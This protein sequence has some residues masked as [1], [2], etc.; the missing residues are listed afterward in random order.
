[1][2]KPSRLPANYETNVFI[3]CPFD[4]EYQPLFYAIVFAVND[5]GFHPKCAKDE[6]N[7]GRSRIEKIRDLIAECKFSIHDLS[8]VDLDPVNNLPRFNMPFE[9]GLDLGC[10]R[11]GNSYQRRKMVL[12]LDTEQYRY[13]KYIS[14]LAGRDPV[15]HHNNEEEVIDHVRNWLRLWLNPDLVETPSGSLIYQRYQQF[16]VTLPSICAD[17]NWNVNKLPFSDFTWSVSDWIV[18]NPIPSASTA[19]K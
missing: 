6:S 1:M 7:A 14:D 3:N 13:Q 5:L 10:G 16:Q 12:V 17:L 15:A 11:Y 19:N 2:A 8:R 4:D 9:L 18:K